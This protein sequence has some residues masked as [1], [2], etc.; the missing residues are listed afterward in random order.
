[1]PNTKSVGVAFED[2]YLNGA[3]IE[4]ST[5]SST[6]IGANSVTSTGAVT[7]STVAITTATGLQ[8]TFGNGQGFYALSTAITANTTTT[9]AVAGSLAITS[10]ATG[11][12]KLFT[13]DGSK[14]QF[15]GVA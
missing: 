3:V 15:V 5:I 12:G 1:M 7:G 4:N 9:T 11:V 8:I 6:T 10:N 14:W 2:P 13:S